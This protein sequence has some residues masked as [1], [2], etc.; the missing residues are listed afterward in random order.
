[1]ALCLPFRLA[2][3]AEGSIDGLLLLL[4]LVAQVLE[5]SW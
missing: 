3:A 2:A 4:L 1:M 5:R